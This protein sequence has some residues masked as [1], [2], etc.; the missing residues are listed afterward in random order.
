M[1]ASFFSTHVE[2]RMLLQHIRD[3][4]TVTGPVLAEYGGQDHEPFVD[5]MSITSGVIAKGQALEV[6]R[7]GDP[8]ALAHLYSVLI[9]EYV[10][11]SSTGSGSLSGDEL[12]A[13]VDGAL[14]RPA[15]SN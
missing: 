3:G 15:A 2:F 12:H 1:T 8:R 14:R 11:L 10:L 9:N 5:V 4:P 6:V 13:L 7:P